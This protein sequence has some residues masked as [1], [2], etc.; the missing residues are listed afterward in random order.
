MKV[1]IEREECISCGA[2]W[3]ECPDFF[4]EDPDDHLSRVVAKYRLEGDVAAGEAP[5]DLGPCVS[6]A[7]ESCPVAIIHVGT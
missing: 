1:T 4:E 7:A 3:G 2:C 6:Q 5:P